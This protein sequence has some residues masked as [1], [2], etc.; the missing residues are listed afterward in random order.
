MKKSFIKITFFTAFLTFSSMLFNISHAQ[1]W[2]LGGKAGLTSFKING[3]DTYGGINYKYGANIGLVFGYKIITDLNIQA[4]LLYTQAGFKQKFT[5]EIITNNQD[6][7]TGAPIVNDTST[8]YNNSL[9][10]S[11]IQIPILIKKSFSFKG[12]VQPYRKEYSIVDFDIYAGP[13]FG[14]LISPSASF[15][16]L[17]SATK[18]VNDTLRG[19]MGA[20]DIS[21]AHS[22]RMGQQLNVKIT[23]D[24]LHLT[25]AEVLATLS[26]DRSLPKGLN[27]IDVGMVFGGGFSFELSSN[28]KLFIDARYT[29]GL[30]TIDKTYF[31]NTTYSISPGGASDPAIGG[32]HYKESVSTQKLDLKSTGLTFNIGFIKYLGK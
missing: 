28:V 17:V 11:Y 16:S 14:Y 30:F 29:M 21:A 4:E 23:N 15:S 9:T 19:T 1:Q 8:K 18:T 24:S 27:S 2:F 10:L 13:Y 12:G 32:V 5:E 20:T 6:P 22:F 25:A 3:S 26:N 7:A 31:S